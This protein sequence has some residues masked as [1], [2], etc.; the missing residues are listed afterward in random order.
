MD[1]LK[2]IKIPRKT[3]Q[4]RLQINFSSFAKTPFMKL[5][6]GSDKEL[7]VKCFIGGHSFSEW[8]L[9]QRT[10]IGLSLEEIRLVNLL[11]Q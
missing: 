2:E 7:Y 4:K 9:L 6:L 1:I 8:V 10:G 3:L 5:G 11:L